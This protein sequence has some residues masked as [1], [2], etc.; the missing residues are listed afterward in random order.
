MP[1]T[2]SAQHRLMQAAA[3]DPQFARKVGVPQGVAR[4]FTLAD[5]VEGKY[6]RVKPK[7]K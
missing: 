7:Q 3:H 6:G 5:A 1:S 4:E 2:S